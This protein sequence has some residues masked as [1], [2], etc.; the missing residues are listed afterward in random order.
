MGKRYVQIKD[1]AQRPEVPW[2][3]TNAVRGAYYRAIPRT[4]SSGNVINAGDP[5]LARCFVQLQKGGPL[6][7]DLVDLAKLME[8][9]RGGEAA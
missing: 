4:D 1:A 7:L 2:N 3:S 9:R 8:T 6:L 5:A